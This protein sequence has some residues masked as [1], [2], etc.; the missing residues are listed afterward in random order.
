MFKYLKSFIWPSKK[1]EPSSV[2][3]PLTPPPPRPQT[4][5][6]Q[7]KSQSDFFGVTYDTQPAKRARFE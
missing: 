6:R 1:Q 2:P 4:S 7:V 3:V 5:M